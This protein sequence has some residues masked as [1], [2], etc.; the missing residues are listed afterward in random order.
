MNISPVIAE[1]IKQGLDYQVHSVVRP[2]YLIP[3]PIAANGE[4]SPILTSATEGLLTHGSIIADSPYI[5][6]RLKSGHP[7]TDTEKNLNIESLWI[8]GLTSP[9]DYVWAPRYGVVIT[10]FGVA[11]TVY[12]MNILEEYHWYKDFSIVPINIDPVNP[13]NIYAYSYAYYEPLTTKVRP[14]IGTL[15]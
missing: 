13:H 10:Y 12:T 1:W 6:V 11:Y 8:L 5:G 15:V 3:I 2:N 14:P 9:N 7:T 4:G